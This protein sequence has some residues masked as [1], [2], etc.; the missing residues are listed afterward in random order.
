MTENKFKR[1]RENVT[2]VQDVNS[3]AKGIPLKKTLTTRNKSEV[4]IEP[5]TDSNRERSRTKQ[6]RNITTPLFVEELKIIEAAV[7]K[8]SEKNTDITI[9]N[10]IRDTILAKCEKTLGKDIFKQLQDDKWN[11]VKKK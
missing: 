2:F 11:V 3:D 9:S 8:I 1:A 5:N 10:F 6:G 7:S 4:E